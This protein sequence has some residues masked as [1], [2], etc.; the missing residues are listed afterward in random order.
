MGLSVSTGRSRVWVGLALVAVLLAAGC[1]ESTT[2]KETGRTTGATG[3]VNQLNTANQR[4]RS[5]YEA[6]LHV[7]ELKTLDAILRETPPA[8]REM[9]LA[10]ADWK[11]V[12]QAGEAA[13]VGIPIDP[14]LLQRFITKTDAW[15]D[16]QRQQNEAFTLCGLTSQSADSEL[17]D[18]LLA[19]RQLIKTGIRLARQT[20][21]L[22]AEV[23]A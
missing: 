1:A 11:A 10:F 9:E 20:Q 8:L 22:Q 16:N 23:L 5:A 14:N 12:L 21:A 17:F 3:L 13:G 6:Y 19:N 2:G 15:I 4:F 7:Y 18:C